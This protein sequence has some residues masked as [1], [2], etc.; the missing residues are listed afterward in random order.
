[1][2]LLLGATVYTFSIILAVFLAGLG[3]GSAVGA[4]L[5]RK[6]ARPGRVLGWCQFLLAG[7]VAWAAYAIARSLPYW[8]SDPIAPVASPWP[9]FGYDLL[10]CA[11]ALLPPACL[12]G[13]SFPLAL[14][15]AAA[16]RGRDTGRVVGGVYAANTVG[17][18]VGALG[19]GMLIIPHA[20]TQ[21]AERL[22]VGVSALAALIA[23]APRPSGA[24][25]GAPRR[26][27]LALAR[28]PALL[29]SVL[30]LAGLLAWSVP[31]LPD[32]L[33]AY[34][35][36]MLTESHF[37]DEVEFLYVG[38]GLNASVAVTQSL[39][40]VRN[41][42]VSGKVE[43]SSEP[44]DMRLQR[45]LGHLP[46]LVHPR[47]RSVLVVGCGAGVTAGSFVVHPEVE[48]IVICEIEPLIPQVVARHFGKENHDV[49][50]DP[51]VEVVYDDARHFI[52]TTHET[53]D[54]ITSD[55]IHPWVKGAAV[56]YSKEYFELCKR[57]LNPGGVVS[58]WVPLYESSP[59]V[60]KSELATFFAVFPEGT[61]WA[62]EVDYDGYDTVV[63]G[64]V[65][66]TAIDV[67]GMQR[68]LSRRDHSG[69]AQSLDEVGFS[70]VIALLATYAGRGPELRPWLADAQINRD[71]NLRLQY[72]AGMGRRF[73]QENQ[74]HDQMLAYRTFPVGLF[75]ASDVYREAIRSWMGAPR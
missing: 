40:G 36:R 66:G 38:E 37:G 69:V 4:A 20:G 2:S 73:Q 23:F 67:D 62:N 59:D 51:R 71:V 26:P 15:A 63:L 21:N 44:Q 55:P 75:V 60:V 30:L 19:F 28:H 41:F 31:K 14:A 57:R 53:F 10:R 42:H 46:A 49:L 12:W 39:D 48:R 11:W 34:G 8:R 13:A 6:A 74:I 72:L 52:L 3:I 45:M 58:Q 1:L 32:M 9:G 61:V 25:A 29:A 18:I 5:A 35:R 43:A 7:A 16:S 22:L 33:V 17:A 68:R 70:S 64:Q 27:V 50:R 56:L 24:P 54:V 65:D 47:P